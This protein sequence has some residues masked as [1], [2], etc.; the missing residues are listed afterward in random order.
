MRWVLAEVIAVARVPEGDEDMA[1]ILTE[2]APIV[3][4]LDMHLQEQRA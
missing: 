2:F 1:V 3:E 4:S